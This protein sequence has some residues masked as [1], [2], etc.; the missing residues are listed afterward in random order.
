MENSVEEI[1]QKLY[2]ITAQKGYYADFN[3]I[4]FNALTISMDKINTQ[5]NKSKDKGIKMRLWDGEKFLEYANTTIDYDFLKQKILELIQ[6]ADEN[7]KLIKDKSELKIDRKNLSKKFSSSC[8]KEEINLKSITNKLDNIKNE[9]LNLDKDIVNVRTLIRQKKEYHIFANQYRQMS[10]Q[11]SEVL[12]AGI[13]M[14]KTENGIKTVYKVFVDNNISVID[15]LTNSFDELKSDII[16]MK[17]AKPLENAGKYKVILSPKMSGLLA[18]ESFGHGMEADT[19]IR[20]RALAVE[21]IGKKIANSNVSII[22]FPLIEGKH[23]MF[24]FDNEGNMAEK[25]YLVKNGIVNE[26]ISDIYSKTKLGLNSSSNSR[27]ESF[28]HKNYVRM[29]NTYFEKGSD[30]FADMIKKVDDGIFVF[31]CAGGMEDPKGWGVQIQGCFGQRI[32][33][34]ELIDEYYDGFSLTGF[35]PDIMKNI[36]S[37]SKEFEIEG[38]GSCGKGHKEW[39]RVSE[40]GPYLLINEVI[41]G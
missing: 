40:G 27:F 31:D 1:F 20:G 8:F 11:I 6:T 15:K 35:L 23:G 26:P 25:V 21:W 32:K 37:V 34:G 7:Q 9:L 13:V 29:S 5:I 12:V 17:K 33:Q 38:G 4:D 28:D 41:L 36:T 3:F 19:I 18:H 39:V 22:D 24:Y 14:L 2:C 30:S 10:Q 16:K